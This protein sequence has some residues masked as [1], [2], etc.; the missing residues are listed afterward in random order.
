MQ[1]DESL[2]TGIE[3]IDAQ[4]REWVRR[5][6]DVSLAMY[7]AGGAKRL[8]ETL[9]FLKDYTRFHFETEERF[10]ADHRYPELDEHRRK[11]AELHETLVRLEADLEEE[12]ITPTLTE[13]VNTLLSNW[14]IRHIR[15]VD[16]RF[17]AFLKHQERGST[18]GT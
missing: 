14:L 2:V 13:A 12:G 8:V 1:W 16:Q 5:L 17:S 6:E 11:H 10:M 7:S 18:P 15:D 9:D 3:L 4:H